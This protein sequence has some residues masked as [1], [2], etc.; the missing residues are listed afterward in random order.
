[1]RFLTGQ[2]DISGNAVW[3]R[4]PSIHCAGLRSQ[5]IVSRLRNSSM[6]LSKKSEHADN[7]LGGLESATLHKPH[8]RSLIWRKSCMTSTI[9]IA[10]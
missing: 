5:H 9:R 1:V 7:L 2:S 10:V 6:E 8:K 3:Q 4:I